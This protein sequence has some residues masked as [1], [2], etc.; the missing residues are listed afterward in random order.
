MGYTFEMILLG[1]RFIFTAEPEN[2]KALLSSQFNDFGELTI[3][4]SRYLLTSTDRQ[5]RGIS[6]ELGPISGWCVVGLYHIS[7]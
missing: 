6:E 4:S 5:G 1:H 7:G 2:I 3:A